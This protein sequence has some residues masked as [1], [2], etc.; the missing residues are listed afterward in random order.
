[1]IYSIRDAVE[2]RLVAAHA[3]T[4]VGDEEGL[5]ILAY[6]LGAAVILVP[7]AGAIYAFSNGAATDAAAV[8]DA[9]IPG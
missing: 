8:V 4:L 9:A 6:A 7:M 3:R 1:M 2:R 5:T